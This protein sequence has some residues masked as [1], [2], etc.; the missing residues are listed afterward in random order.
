MVEDPGRRTDDWRKIKILKRQDCVVLG[1]TPGEKG[2]ADSFGAL[3]VGA[4]KDGKLLWIGQV[5]SG[6]T[7]QMLD[8]LMKRLTELETDHPPIDSAEL[9]KV[10]GAHWVRPELVCEVEYLQ[11]TGVGKLRAP[12]F[13]GLRPDKLPEDCILEPPAGEDGQAG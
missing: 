6:F 1:R 5:G 12:V 11:M 8:I 9:R 2:R 13:K 4:Y 10:K 3:L 7:D